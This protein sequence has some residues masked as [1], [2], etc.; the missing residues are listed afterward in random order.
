MSHVDNETLIQ[1][2]K[3]PEDCRGL[4]VR[5]AGYSALFVGLCK[6]VQGEIINRTALGEE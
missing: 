4:I 6:E 5:V 3:H 1:A 2:Q